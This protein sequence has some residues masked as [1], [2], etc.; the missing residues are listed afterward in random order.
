MR[1]I[2]ELDSKDQPDVRLTPAPGAE[3]APAAP[4]PSNAGATDAGPAPDVAT[5]QPG[6]ANGSTGYN[7]PN[8]SNGPLPPIAGA[9]RQ[10]AEMMSA[11][12]APEFSIN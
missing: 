8:G 9:V 1:I 10:S 11:G 5:L 7:D 12:S 6:L 4:G 2:I 3:L